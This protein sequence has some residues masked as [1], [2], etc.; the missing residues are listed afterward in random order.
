MNPSHSASHQLV[1]GHMRYCCG[2]SVDRDEIFTMQLP[3]PVMAE[4]AFGLIAKYGW[5]LIISK[6]VDVFGSVVTDVGYRGEL[7]MQLAC[8]MASSKSRAVSCN[9]EIIPV[10]L[11]VFIWKRRILSNF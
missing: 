7:G 3:E 5:D 10:P 11:E 2:V 1:A 8:I 9:R 6:V 4:A